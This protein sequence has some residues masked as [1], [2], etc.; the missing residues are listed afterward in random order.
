MAEFVVFENDGEHLLRELVCPYDPKTASQAQASSTIDPTNVFRATGS[1]GTAA[2]SDFCFFPF[3][4]LG[5][6]GRPCSFLVVV[7][8]VERIGISYSW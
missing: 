5:A 8:M 6:P 4:L 3:N 7:G 2:A 1:S